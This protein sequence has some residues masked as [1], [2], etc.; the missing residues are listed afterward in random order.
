MSESEDRRHLM[1]VGEGAPEPAETERSA[2]EYACPVPISWV[3]HGRDAV[4]GPHEYRSSGLT[5]KIESKLEGVE[6]KVALVLF[7]VRCP[8]IQLRTL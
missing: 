8:H 6:P 2:Y 4:V 1:L 3:D 7:C 5:K